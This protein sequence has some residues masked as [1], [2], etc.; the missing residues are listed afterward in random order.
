[1]ISTMLAMT[2]AATAAQA[3]PVNDARRAYS[4]CMR[5]FM[6]TSL[7]QRMEPAAFE[8]ALNAQCTERAAAYREALIRRDARNGGGRARAEQD[9]EMTIEDTKAN[10]LEYYRDYYENEQVPD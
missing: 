9:A 2:L 10:T 5:G 1:M 8:T 6:R 3:D 7:Q 4:D